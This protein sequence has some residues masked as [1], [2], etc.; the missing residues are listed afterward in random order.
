MA[1]KRASPVARKNL[2][3]NNLTSGKGGKKAGWGND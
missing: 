3:I 2:K 1:T